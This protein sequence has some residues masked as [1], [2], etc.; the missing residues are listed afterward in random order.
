MGFR[1]FVS[2]FELVVETI[3]FACFKFKKVVVPKRQAQYMIDFRRP[4]FGAP[5]SKQM[6]SFQAKRALSRRAWY[7]VWMTSTGK[8]GVKSLCHAFGHKTTFTLHRQS[9]YDN[10]FATHKRCRISWQHGVSSMDSFSCWILL[11]AGTSPLPG[12]PPSA[13]PLAVRAHRGREYR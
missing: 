3:E 9:I 1:F 13:C 4:R 11:L 2:S 5:G 6:C 10:V 8:L 12:V 7:I